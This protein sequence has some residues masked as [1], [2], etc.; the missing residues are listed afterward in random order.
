MRMCCEKDFAVIYN[1]CI[2]FS[3]FAGPE[4]IP[5]DFLTE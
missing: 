3:I 5:G 1:C 2:D 4:I